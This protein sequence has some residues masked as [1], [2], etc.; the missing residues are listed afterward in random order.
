MMQRNYFEYQYQ[1]NIMSKCQRKKTD[2]SK[3]K[4]LP[5]INIQP[6]NLTIQREKIQQLAIKNL[7]DREYTTPR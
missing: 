3:R 7:S 2:T 6:T 4:D 5:S 1:K